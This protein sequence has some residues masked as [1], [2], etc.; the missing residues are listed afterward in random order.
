MKKRSL[1]LLALFLLFGARSFASEPL[2]DLST[3][4]YFD[5]A[6]F[7]FIQQITKENPQHHRGGGGRFMPEKGEVWIDFQSR[8]NGDSYEM[9]TESRQSERLL[10]TTKAVVS[11]FGITER[12]V[13]YDETGEPSYS[14]RY[15]ATVGKGFVAYLDEDGNQ[16]EKSVTINPDAYSMMTIPYIIGALRIDD[17]ERHSLHALV[18]DG[19][20]FGLYIQEIDREVVLVGGRSYTCSK[21]ECGFSG[22]IGLFAPKLLFWVDEKSR[23]P[24]KQDMM[25]GSIIE[26]ERVYD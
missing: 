10:Y 1:F 26:V 11:R 2:F 3:I 14:Y 21:I 7:A 18:G 20:T 19:R 6:H 16:V 25:G 5:D 8:R 22:I 23:I 24:V 17:T 13:M 15:D 4:S 12:Y 9:V